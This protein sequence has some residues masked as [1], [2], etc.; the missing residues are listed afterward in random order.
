MGL[1]GAKISRF[2][3]SAR[4]RQWPW[5][6]QKRNVDANCVQG[7]AAMLLVE[8]HGIHQYTARDGKTNGQRRTRARP[9]VVPKRPPAQGAETKDGDE[10]MEAL[11]V[12]HD[13]RLSHLEH[14]VEAKRQVSESAPSCFWAP[15][16][17]AELGET[18]AGIEANTPVINVR[19]VRHGGTGQAG[20]HLAPSQEARW[21]SEVAD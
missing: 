9:D 15:K 4:S 20:Y 6:G 16:Y 8:L 13:T 12:Q 21:S 19:V 1:G 10:N 3:G 14:R 7:A 17:R 2:V 11:C 18:G 5:P